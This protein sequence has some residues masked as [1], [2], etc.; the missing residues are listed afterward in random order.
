MSYGTSMPPLVAPTYFSEKTNF[1]SILATRCY[2]EAE[3]S[4]IREILII[5]P[6]SFTGL[7]TIEDLKKFVKEFMKVF[8]VMHVVNIER[9]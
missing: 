7:R 2:N 8:N 9:G 3:T 5:N 1:W 4:R 6:P